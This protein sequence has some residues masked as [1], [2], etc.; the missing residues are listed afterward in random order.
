MSK[1]G[2]V[3]GW[4]TIVNDYIDDIGDEEKIFQN[5]NNINNM[6]KLEQIIQLNEQSTDI[7]LDD[8][9]VINKIPDFYFEKVFQLDN[10]RTFNRVSVNIDLKSHDLVTDD[11]DR[12]NESYLIFNDKLN[13]YLD[14]VEMLLVNNISIRYPS[15]HI[16]FLML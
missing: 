3:D 13:N 5:R 11:K 4:K 8:S 6:N 12:R 15:L 7:Y 16:S 1:F 9:T 2:I 14:C 10:E